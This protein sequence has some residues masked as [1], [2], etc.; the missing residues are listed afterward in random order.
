MQSCQAFYSQEQN[1][2]EMPP[3]LGA[4]QAFTELIDSDL[5]IDTNV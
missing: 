2:T 1:R 4:A 5:S 3:D